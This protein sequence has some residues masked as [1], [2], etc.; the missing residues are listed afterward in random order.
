MYYFSVTEMTIAWLVISILGT[1]VVC[2]LLSAAAPTKDEI[3][4]IETVDDSPVR[5]EDIFL[6]FEKEY[7]THSDK[8]QEYEGLLVRAAMNGV[9]Q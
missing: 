7:Q 8:I 5:R 2:F 9:V 3:S 1:I 4:N 6:A